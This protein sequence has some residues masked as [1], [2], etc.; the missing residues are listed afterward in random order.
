M[1][2]RREKPFLQPPTLKLLRANSAPQPN[3]PYWFS[4][5]HSARCSALLLARPTDIGEPAKDRAIPHPACWMLW[6]CRRRR[7][8]SPQAQASHGS[9]VICWPLLRPHFVHFAYALNLAKP[10]KCGS[11]SVLYHL[12]HI[13]CP[14]ANRAETVEE[15]AAKGWR[16]PLC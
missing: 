11:P 16:I 10:S 5:L 4:S 3:F 1:K 14:F 6:P 12:E 15:A 2:L 7:T 13:L 8:Q 9:C